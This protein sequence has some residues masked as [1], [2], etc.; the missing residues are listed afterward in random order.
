MLPSVLPCVPL[1]L[2]GAPKSMKVLY[3]MSK[4]RLYRK[5]VLFDKRRHAKRQSR[6]PVTLPIGLATRFLDSATL[7][8]ERLSSF[9][10]D[11]IDIYP[12]TRPIEA[13]VAIDQRKNCVIASKS[14]VFP[15]QKFRSALAHNNISSYNHLV[16]K[17]FHA[18]PLADAVATVFDA[19]LSFFM[20]HWGG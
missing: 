5:P 9:R 8:S 6:D 1:P 3:F 16:S 14:H 15:G 10:S 12:P 20:S 19:A 4:V 18:E 13:H 11:R 17:S 2:P 7:R